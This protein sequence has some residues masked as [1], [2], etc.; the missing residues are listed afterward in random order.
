MGEPPI[1]DWISYWG[2]DLDYCMECKK[3]KELFPQVER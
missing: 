1:T 3:G 2:H